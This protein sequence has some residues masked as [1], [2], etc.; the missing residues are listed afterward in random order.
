MHKRPGRFAL[1]RA[2]QNEGGNDMP[3]EN[4]VDQ[5][6][7]LLADLGKHRNSLRDMIRRI[8]GAEFDPTTDAPRN[9]AARAIAA[10]VHLADDAIPQLEEFLGT[11][12]AEISEHG[13]EA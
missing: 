13:D 4:V 3:I 9:Q 8:E 10:A 12:L 2:S 11:A 7:E 6:K 5:M 1:W